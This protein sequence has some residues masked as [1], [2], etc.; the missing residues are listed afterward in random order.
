MGAV[1]FSF[2]FG[3]LR[4]GYAS[5][6]QIETAPANPTK[7]ASIN[8]TH[9]FNVRKTSSATRICKMTGTT[10]LE[11]PYSLDELPKRCGAR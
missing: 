9:M 4:T 3:R 2:G 10:C 1:G 5:G 8:G 7:T 6:G 11:C